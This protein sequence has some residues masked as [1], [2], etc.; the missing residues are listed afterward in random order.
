MKALQELIELCPNNARGARA[1]AELDSLEARLTALSRIVRRALA[2]GQ[3]E[4]LE[5]AKP[6]L[7]DAE[8]PTP[9]EAPAAN[10]GAPLNPPSAYPRS[11]TCVCGE[12]YAGTHL[13]LCPAWSD[14][15]TSEVPTETRKQKLT[16]L[17]ADRDARV[18]LPR[19]DPN[20]AREAAENSHRLSMVAP[21]IDPLP[22][23]HPIVDVRI[24]TTE[25]PARQKLEHQQGFC[26]CD[27]CLPPVETK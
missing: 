3:I 6:Y 15:L 9:T 18:G 26:L 7:D 25:T 1:R 11:P 19:N 16:R 8:P 10:W 12:A 13:R 17:E 20:A 27:A 23:P 5:D 2:S 22:S 21:G 24:A 14:P 4:K